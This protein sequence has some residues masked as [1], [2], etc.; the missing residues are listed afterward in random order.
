M[1]KVSYTVSSS[2]LD[3]DSGSH[4]LRKSSKGKMAESHGGVREKRVSGDAIPLPWVE[5]KPKKSTSLDS[6]TSNLPPTDEIPLEENGVSRHDDKKLVI[7]LKWIDTDVPIEEPPEGN[8]PSVTIMEAEKPADLTSFSNSQIGNNSASV[9]D[10]IMSKSNDTLQTETSDASVGS[11]TESY[12]QQS[13]VNTDDISDKFNSSLFQDTKLLTNANNA[14]VVTTLPIN[15]MSSTAGLVTNNSSYNVTSF[16]REIDQEAII[17]PS[18]FTRGISNELIKPR[19]PLSD[20]D[21]P[22]HNC[23][24]LS[25]TRPSSDLPDSILLLTKSYTRKKRLS[26]SRGDSP[27]CS[28]KPLV[29][30][31]FNSADE[32]FYESLSASLDSLRRDMQISRES[33]PFSTTPLI[34]AEITEENDIGGDI[35]NEAE[36]LA[37]Y[38]GA[39]V[40]SPLTSDDVPVASP[41]GFDFRKERSVS[42]MRRL[43]SNGG[44]SVQLSR[45]ST[46]ATDIRRRFKARLK[47][48]SLQEAASTGDMKTLIELLEGG[49]VDVDATDE[50][51]R[52][53]L[54]LA[55]DRGQ[56]EVVS[57]LLTKECNVNLP[58]ADGRTP[59][60]C[61]VESGEVGVVEALLAAGADVDVREKIRGRT[62]IHFATVS[63]SLDVLK[64]RTFH[65]QLL[66]QP[67]LADPWEAMRIFKVADKDGR[68]LLHMTAHHG[69]QDATALLL[70]AGA[71]VNAKDFSGYTPMHAAILTRLRKKE[72]LCAPLLEILLESGGDVEGMGG[73]Y[74]AGEAGT[75]MHAAASV[76]CMKCLQVLMK[77]SAQIESKDSSRKTPLHIAIEEEHLE[78]TSFLLDQK[79][80]M[81]EVDARGQRALHH[82][83]MA[84]SLCMIE[85]LLNAGADRKAKDRDGKTYFQ[86]A[87][88]KRRYQALDALVKNKV[89]DVGEDQRAIHFCANVGN[90]T[91]IDVLLNN[92]YDINETDNDGRI[93]LHHAI[94]SGHEALVLHLLANGS[95]SNRA[96]KNGATPL[97][98]AVRWGGSDA[99]LR[100]LVK[101]QGNVGA[102]DRL[103]R[104]PLHYAASKSSIMSD[105][106]I[107]INSGAKINTKDDRGL[108]PLHLAARLGNESLVRILLDNDARHD[109]RDC[110]DFLPIDHARENGHKCIIKRLEAYHIKKQ[111]EKEARLDF[112]IGN[113]E[114]KGS[115][116]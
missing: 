90:Q 14:G 23:S 65:L 2:V 36:L 76:G 78:G 42:V 11:T 56:L 34:L 59:L 98:Y 35:V 20:V 21:I 89:T 113:M 16:P 17:L 107:L 95:S 114:D 19:Y 43:L 79:A 41:V 55:A 62:P 92:G 111:R 45:E 68:T 30:H 49:E 53:A 80:S 100:R 28:S 5:K 85:L 25:K 9:T 18:R 74:S 51:E 86:F 52:T 72:Y 12:D 3:V 24:F 46:P 104:T 50:K 71:E 70:S 8:Q 60:H 57:L 40:L 81:E 101:M 67:L 77:H 6:D 91:A 47:I 83:I 82:A 66:I 64:G 29:S 33:T 39:G 26:G 97:H 93:A 115:I 63:N 38:H 32:S 58:D 75:L 99:L 109:I 106:Y 22:I 94:C 116:A 4:A 13:A 44:G 105:M 84:D 48:A 73:D 15:V 37:T 102:V 112:Y 69:L 96:D 110:D 87:L 7:A 54:H 27:V 108:T 1:S 61:A 31:R 103:G 88:L 10:N